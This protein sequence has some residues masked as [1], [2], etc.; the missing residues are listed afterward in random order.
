MPG[1]A[2][3]EGPRP[4]D[5][6]EAAAPDPGLAAGDRSVADDSKTHT[7]FMGADFAVSLDKSLYPVRGVVGSSWVVEINGEEKIIPAGRAPLTLKITPNL[8]LTERSATIADYKKE[9]AYTFAND[10]STRITRGLSQAAMSNLDLMANARDAQA[11]ADTQSN[12]A[13]GAASVFA[14]SDNQLGASAIHAYNPSSGPPPQQG[15]FTYA[16]AV[17][18]AKTYAVDVTAA[19]S[20][21]VAF[22]QQNADAALAQAQNGNEP[23]GRLAPTGMDAMEVEFEISSA[24]PLQKPYVITITQ[25]HPKGTRPS[26]VQN[27]VYARELGPIDAQPAK[28]HFIEGGFPFDFE[29]VDFQL[30]LYNQGVEVATTE[31]SKR[32]QLTRDE[33][34]EYVKIEYLAAHKAETLPAVPALAVLPPDLRSQLATGAFKETVYVRVS[35]EGHAAGAFADSKCS[36]PIEDPNF[37][38]VVR[39]IRFYPALSAGEAVDGI[40][41]LNLAQLKF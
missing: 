24:R 14:S 26:T 34:Y 6:A 8:K 33:A 27:L 2:A 5:E 1:A 21:N 37:A 25:F 15:N 4:P 10:P 22:A 30:H 31:S 11:A 38:R 17:A 41:S 16:E 40:A 9:R 12:K 28:V 32:V 7:L 36:R 20:Q 3:F 29:V 39:A 23:G 35:K 19:Q 18:M 13:L